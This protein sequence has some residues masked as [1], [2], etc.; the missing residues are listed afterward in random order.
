MRSRARNKPVRVQVLLTESER[1]AFRREA[2][3]R[4]QS[5]S[6]WLRESGIERLEED[7]EKRMSTAAELKK[8]FAECGHR[9]KEREPDWS[10]HQRVM[11]TSRGRGRSN[12]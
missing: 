6:G 4:G 7:A 5:L 10:D 11:E 3:L 2:E 1:E 9:E 12:T 8:F